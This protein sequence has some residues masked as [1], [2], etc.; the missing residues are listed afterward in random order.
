LYE[1]PRTRLCASAMEAT[2]NRSY[3]RGMNSCRRTSPPLWQ[4]PTSMFHLRT[5]S[6]VT[7]YEYIAKIWTSGPKRFI[8]DP[9]KRMPGLNTEHVPPDIDEI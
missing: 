9:V 1:R 6:D 7:P 3:S 5:L 2:A 8:V 4:H